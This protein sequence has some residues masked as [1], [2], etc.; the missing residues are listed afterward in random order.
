MLWETTAFLTVRRKAPIKGGTGN[1]KG[2][3]DIEYSSVDD[4]N[5]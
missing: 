2:S 3:L 5:Y 4:H 1:I